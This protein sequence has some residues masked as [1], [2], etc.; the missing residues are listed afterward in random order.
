MPCIV[1]VVLKISSRCLRC[2]FQLRSVLRITCITSMIICRIPSAF[3]NHAYV[4]RISPTF[5][6]IQ[7]QYDALGSARVSNRAMGRRHG[8]RSGL[9]LNFRSTQIAANQVHQREGRTLSSP[10]PPSP[11]LVSQRQLLF[12]NTTCFIHAVDG[13][14]TLRVCSDPT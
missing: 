5:V 13:L 12:P 11:L 4:E 10:A 6:R 9:S 8:C 2:I 1:E 3:Q 14:F 7:L